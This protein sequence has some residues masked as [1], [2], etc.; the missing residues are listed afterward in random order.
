MYKPKPFLQCK[1]WSSLVHCDTCEMDGS[2][3][4]LL[5]MI[6]AQGP[7]TI[8]E[9]RWLFS[10]LLERG[11]PLWATLVGTDGHTEGQ[12]PRQPSTRGL[13]GP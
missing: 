6:N 13:S 3:R 10:L 2:E 11:G 7:P 12:S 5:R 4:I 1:Y 8:S 9:G